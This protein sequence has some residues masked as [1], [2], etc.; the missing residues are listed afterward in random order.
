MIKRFVLKMLNTY[1]TF[2]FAKKSKVGDNFSALY[3]SVCINRNNNKHNIA[4]GNNVEIFG[5]VTA[6]AGAII[7][8][9]DY[10]TIRYDTEIVANNSIIIGNEVIISNNCIIYDNNTHPISPAKRL[11]MSHSGFHSDLWSN[12]HAETAPVVIEDNVWI[13][14]RAMILK[15]VRIGKG[16]IVAAGAVVTKDVPPYSIVAGNPAKIVKK[17]N[18]DPS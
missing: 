16:S 14:Q 9:G 15:G 6:N 5:R 4:I 13:C 8:I 3:P 17:L 7:T 1:S 2:K 11:E 18:Y 10:T 12:L